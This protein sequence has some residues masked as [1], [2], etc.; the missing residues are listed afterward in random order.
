MVERRRDAEPVALPALREVE[1]VALVLAVAAVDEVEAALGSLEEQLVVLAGSLGVDV[2]DDAVERVVR[3]GFVLVEQAGL[4][5]HRAVLVRLGTVPVVADPGEQLVRRGDDV[6]LGLVL[7]L[8]LEHG[9]WPFVVT[10][11]ALILYYKYGHKST[12]RIELRCI[13]R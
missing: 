4:H 8:T 11:V 5:G 1:P 3:R 2:D 12:A 7:A 10:T 6:E 9:L 13:S